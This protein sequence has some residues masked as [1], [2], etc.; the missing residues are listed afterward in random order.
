MSL[1]S[2]ETVDSAMQAGMVAGKWESSETVDTA[3]QAGMVAGKWYSGRQ[4][5]PRWLQ[6]IAKLPADTQ[7]DLLPETYNSRQPT[8]NEPAGKICKEAIAK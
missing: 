4:Q 8:H 5:Q 7:R 1:E 3:M 6:T 2:S